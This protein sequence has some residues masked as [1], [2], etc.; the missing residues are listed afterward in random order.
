MDNSG[1]RVI[2]MAKKKP[3]LWSVFGGGFLA[4]W[5][6]FAV[7]AAF[8]LARAGEMN[9]ER[10]AVFDLLTK[11]FLFSVM[12]GFTGVALALIERLRSR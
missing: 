12:A 2:P 7:Y 5:L 6:A 3:A 9:L 1:D 11:G 8:G 4:V 10:A